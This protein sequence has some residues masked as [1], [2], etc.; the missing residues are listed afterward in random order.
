M[1][2]AALPIHGQ[3]AADNTPPSVQALHAHAA[4][5]PDAMLA[6]AP[7]SA[8]RAL[9]PDDTLYLTLA[10]GRVVIE[11]APQFAPRYVANIRKLVRQGFFNGLPIFRV[12][13]DAVVE[14]GDATGRRSVGLARRAVAA[15][16]E[17]P[18]RDLPFTALPDP[19]TYAPQVGFSDGFPV[20]RDPVFG[21]S[22]LVNCYGMVGAARGNNVDSGG[23]TALYAVIGGPERQWDRNATMVGRVVEGMP[24]LSTL[25]RGEGPLG[26]Y[27]NR[28]QWVRV[29]SVQIAADLPAGQRTPLEVLRTDTP[30]FTQ[31]VESLRNRRGPWFKVPAGRASVCAIPI[32]V[33]TKAGN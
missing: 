24:L 1:A 22:W 2:L 4:P 3:D 23:G 13:D 14:W 31:Y 25:P 7:A 20:A 11:L 19:D 10:Q 6:D 28:R 27:M 9:D 8:W 17:R 30:T 12:Q 18:S 21:R 5:T 29:E 26:V 32:P 16:F 33:R 15:E